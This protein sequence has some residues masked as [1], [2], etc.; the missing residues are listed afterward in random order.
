ML[1]SLTDSIELSFIT[2]M[3]YESLENTIKE[4]EDL[5]EESYLLIHGVLLMSH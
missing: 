3:N 2:A 1:D 5:K 4:C